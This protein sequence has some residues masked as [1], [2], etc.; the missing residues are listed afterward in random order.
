M[1]FNQQ[2]EN[3]QKKH[4]ANSPMKNVT[5]LNKISDSVQDILIIQPC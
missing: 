2:L 4:W 1:K 3:L 5:Y